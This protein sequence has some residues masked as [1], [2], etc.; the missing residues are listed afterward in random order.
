MKSHEKCRI[1]FS[2]RFFLFF[3]VCPHPLLASEPVALPQPRFVSDTSVE[4]ALLSRR[5]IRSYRKEPLTLAEVSQILWAAQ[6]VT[7]PKKGLRSAPSARALFLLHVYFFAGEVTGLP[8]GMYKYN[9]GEHT[10]IVVRDGDQKTD[11]YQA[12]NQGPVKDAPAALVITGL[13]DKSSNSAWMYLEAGHAAQNVYLQAVP[14]NIG[15]VVMAGFSPEKLKKA[16]G[17]PEN[18]QPIYVMP[19]GKRPGYSASPPSP[20]PSS[21]R[22]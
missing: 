12:V 1:L 9:P 16:L 8:K 13:S 11:L 20:P 15:T 22:R 3:L 14:L 4:A 18:E 6:G 19:L 2:I 21:H 7:E 5:S 10:L 17:F